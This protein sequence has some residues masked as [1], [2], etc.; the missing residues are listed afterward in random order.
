MELKIFDVS[1]GFCA[2]L[3]A[4]NGNTMLFDCGHN[5][6]TGFRPSIYLPRIGINI[7]NR[8]IVQNFDQ[9][10]VSDLHNIRQVLSI[11]VF[12]RNRTLA[13]EVLAALKRQS[14]P[15]TTAMQATIDLHTDYIHPVTIPPVFPGIEMVQFNNT[16]PFFTD[17]NNLSLV[18]FVHY[19]GMGIA[20]TGDMEKAGWQELLKNPDFCAH[21]RRV[22]IFVASHHGRE[23][24]YCEEV[25]RY[26]N[27]DII[28]IS[29]RNKIYE[30]QEMDYA[31]HARGV[32]WNGGPDKRY[33]LTTRCDG[34]I[35]ISKNTGAG[36]FVR[37]AC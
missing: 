18:S 13:P 30:T 12:H 28:I 15:I 29:D 3:V 35:T 16:Y 4:D 20:L 9:D 32:T 1:H 22:N 23:S 31:R 21:L 14:G 36:Y 6:V 26:C 17:T 37:T 24:G 33:V 25:F 11:G 7:I 10:H 5:E 8:L 34:M 19:D 27:P 2:F